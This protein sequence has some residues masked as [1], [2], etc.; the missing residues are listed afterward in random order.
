LTQVL[1]LLISL[2]LFIPDHSR[3]GWVVDRFNAHDAG[4]GDL[5]G[6]DPRSGLIQDLSRNGWDIDSFNALMQGLVIWSWLSC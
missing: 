3:N 6:I 2:G 4:S 1:E 5:S